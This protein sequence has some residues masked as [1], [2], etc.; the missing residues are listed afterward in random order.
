MQKKTDGNRA[1]RIP[2]YENRQ[3]GK[4]RIAGIPEHPDTGMSEQTVN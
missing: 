2:D 4:F 1:V 3:S